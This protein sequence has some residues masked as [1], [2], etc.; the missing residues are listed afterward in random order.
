[1]GRPL[2][3]LKE[4]EQLK[5]STAFYEKAG[6]TLLSLQP[7]DP[8]GEDTHGGKEWE[9]MRGHMESRISSLRQWQYSWYFTNW[10]DLANFILP[11]RSLW[12]T[13]S[14]GNM[15]NPNSNYRGREINQAIVDPTATYAVRVAAAGLMSGLASPSRP[16]FK[17]IPAI[18]G[19]PMDSDGRGWLDDVEDRFYTVLA[20]SNFYSSFAQECEDLLVF[21]TAPSVM[22]EDDKDIIRLYNYC[23]G[24]Y[25]LSVDTAQRVDGVY[26]LFVMTVQQMVGFFGVDNCPQ[27]VQELWKQKGAGLAIEKIIG[28]AIEPNYSIY[29]DDAGVIPGNFTWREIYWTY[30]AGANRPLSRRGFVEQPFTCAR[31]STQSNDAYGRSPGM[32]VL[33]DVIQLQVETRRKAEGIEKQVRPPLVADMSLKNQPSS[34]LPGHVT[35]VNQLGP[36]KGMRPIYQVNPDLKAMVEDISQIQQRI[37]RGLFN[38]LFLMLEQFPQQGKMTAYEVAQKI[39]EKLQVLGPVIESMLGDLKLKLKRLYR[40]MQRK[41]MLPPPPDSMKGIP[42]DIEFVSIL[43]LAQKAAATG[44]IERIVALVGNMVAVYPGAASVLNFEETIRE[45][46]DLLGNPDKILHSAEEVQA[47]VQ[48]QNQQAQAQAQAQQAESV[49]KTA[50]T[51]ADAAQVLS[52]TQIGGANSALASIL[53]QN[54]GQ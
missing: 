5:N 22:Y 38:D 1:M 13:Q 7:G 20:G 10:S 2:L 40:I 21:G 8:S 49:A 53:G 25:Y 37:Q 42:L 6:A 43:A 27:D 17:M 19:V 12:L 9:T 50:S 32:D 26:R 51:G 39:Q 4:K 15:P 28:H 31:W 23:V 3:K 33:P 29:P 45:M 48:Q 47:A 16:W 35:Y 41:N 46:N 30:G 36:D 18:K 11:R 52:Q 24:E 14:V 34:T 54:Q 44:G